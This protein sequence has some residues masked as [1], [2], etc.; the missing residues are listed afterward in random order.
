VCGAED[1]LTPVAD[2]E[3]IQRGVPGSRLEIIPKAGH[4][5]ALEDPAAFNAALAGFLEAR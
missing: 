4:L 1:A 3:A 5:S 2:A